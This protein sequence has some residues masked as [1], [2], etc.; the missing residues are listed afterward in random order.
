[1]CS[2][3]KAGVDVDAIGLF[4]DI[5]FGCRAPRKSRCGTCAHNLPMAWRCP[6]RVLSEPLGNRRKAPRPVIARPA[7]QPH[8]PAHDRSNNAVSVVLDLMNPAGVARRFLHG[9]GAILG[10]NGMPNS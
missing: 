2:L 8:T 5:A 9:W 10:S 3:P 1:M 4:L 6:L 7:D